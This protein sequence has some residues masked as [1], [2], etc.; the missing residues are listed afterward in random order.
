MKKEVN[1]ARVI[2][3][4]IVPYR[5]KDWPQPQ[6]TISSNPSPVQHFPQGPRQK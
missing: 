5:H 6:M 1:M 3:T 4:P 2:Q